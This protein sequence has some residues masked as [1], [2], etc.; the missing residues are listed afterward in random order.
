MSISLTRDEFHN[1]L[2]ERRNQFRLIIFHELEMSRIPDT[3]PSIKN[4]V[5]H[6]EI[7]L[8]VFLGRQ[9]GAILDRL[10]DLVYDDSP[11]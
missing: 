11:G 8:N 5:L 9:L 1:R 10:V 2:E 7:N 3:P 4:G 6:F